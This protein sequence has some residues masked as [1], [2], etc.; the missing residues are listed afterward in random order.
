MAVADAN[1]SDVE[2]ENLN[3]ASSSKYLTKSAK[4]KLKAQGVLLNT[5]K[6]GQIPDSLPI[7]R[8]DNYFLPRKNLK[9]ELMNQPEIPEDFT[10][11]IILTDRKIV[12]EVE[13]SEDEIL[14][15]RCGGDHVLKTSQLQG[16]E[17]TLKIFE[18]LQNL[19][20]DAGDIFPYRY[21]GEAKILTDKKIRITSCKTVISPS[22]YFVSPSKV[23]SW[24]TN[25]TS[26]QAVPTIIGSPNIVSQLIFTNHQ[27][28]YINMGGQPAEIGQSVQV[29]SQ[30]TE[31]PTGEIRIVDKFG[32]FA[33]GI[34][35]DV[36]DLIETG[37]E[38][39]L[40]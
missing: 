33:I 19:E 26:T 16:S 28:A 6:P 32:S 22:L 23:D 36:Q 21:V 38:V 24:R 27:F 34:V 37:D 30:L 7:S 29:Q 40:K 1:D 10:S 4:N 20:T 31:R 11:D 2:D 18:S 35:T 9:V 12:S 25:K 15:G 3:S 8:N 5:R 17:G 13:V 39:R 14:K